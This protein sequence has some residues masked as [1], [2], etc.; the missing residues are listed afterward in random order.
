MNAVAYMVAA[1]VLGAL[2][3]AQPILNAILARAIGS[4]YGATTLAIFLAFLCSFAFIAV[5]GGGDFSV[6][7]LTSVPWWVYLTSVIGVTYVAAGVVIAPVTGA[8][9]FFVCVVA[10]QLIGSA[11]IDH[12]GMF[13]I[14]VRQIS[15][16]RMIG[17]ALVLGG[18]I[19]VSRG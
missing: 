1:I 9:L 15:P 18:A 10:G 4:P 11:L 17:L 12:F 6:R 19:L 2:V 14:S 3:T 8:F 16:Q 7:T 13:G 5:K